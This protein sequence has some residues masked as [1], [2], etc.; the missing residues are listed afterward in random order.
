MSN[1]LAPSA[2]LTLMPTLLPRSTSSP[3]PHPTDA[4]SVLVHAIHT[5]LGFRLDR[6]AS[7]TSG[8]AASERDDLHAGGEADSDVEVDD[9]ASET[10]TAVD[11]EAE[12]SGGDSGLGASANAARLAQGWNHRAEDSYVF[13]YRHEQSSMEFVIRIGRM[14]G[15]V[16]VDA[17]AAVSRFPSAAP[18]SNV[19]REMR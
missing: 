13:K 9:A 5:Q 18:L 6:P 8:D 19:H 3:L 17:M 11:A 2:L 14:G 16:Q 15:R 4:V 10:T 12:E 7:S 1:P